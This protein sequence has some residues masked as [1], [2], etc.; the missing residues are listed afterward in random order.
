MLHSGSRGIGNRIGTHFIAR[1]RRR[2]EL[3]GIT[4]PHRDLAWLPE[5]T[6]EFDR[7]VRAVRWCQEYAFRNRDVML[8]QVMRA[9]SQALGRDVVAIDTAINCH[10]DYVEEETHFGERLW[11][12]RKGAVAAF[13]G[14]RG[15]I[16]RSMGAKSFIVE[17]LGNADSFMS[18]RMHGRTADSV[19][20]CD[21]VEP[22]MPRWYPRRMS[23]RELSIAFVV[24]LVSC[25][26]ALFLEPPY[27]FGTKLDLL[28][29][30]IAAGALGL[31]LLLLR[32]AR[33]QP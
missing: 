24:A 29:S 31:C 17:G 9:V 33:R 7:Y 32:A 15:I 25:G 10:H 26:L 30:G 2:A 13:P 27:E 6:P 5:G 3:D 8:G 22:A 20:C 14:R 21:A 12:T 4:L 19:S 11:I 18:S 23:A 16:P 28:V 1:A